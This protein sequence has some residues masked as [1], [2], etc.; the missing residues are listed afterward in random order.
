MNVYVVQYG[1]VDMTDEV[2][3]NIYATADAARAAAIKD[4]EDARDGMGDEDYY[5]T[6]TDELIS[7]FDES[8]EVTDWWRI[9]EMEVR[10]E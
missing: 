6:K 3:S 7:V 9:T 4:A 5:V 8:D 10:G 2:L 1:C